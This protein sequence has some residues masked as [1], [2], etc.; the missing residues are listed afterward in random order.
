MRR[1]EWLMLGWALSGAVWAAELRGVVEWHRQPVGEA[2]VYLDVVVTQAMA[3]AG[4]VVVDFHRGQPQPRVSVAMCGAELLLQNSDATLRIARV[5]AFDRER[6]ATVLA[7]LAMPY[8][9]FE[10]RLRLP[11]C[12]APTLVRVVGENGGEQQRAFVA[13]LPH[14][15][16]AVTGGDGT[17]VLEDVP[18]GRWRLCVWQ[19]QLGTHVEPVTISGSRSVTIR[20]PVAAKP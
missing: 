4:P 6:N 8:A 9:G 1:L 7:R 16:A 12:S 20:W 14:R 10:K 3:S 19:E 18:R 5:E 11:P 2:V 15:W 13:V 17:F